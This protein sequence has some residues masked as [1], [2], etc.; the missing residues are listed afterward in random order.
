MLPTPAR[1][2]VSLA[3]ITIMHAELLTHRKTTQHG[4]TRSNAACHCAASDVPFVGTGAG[5][6]QALAVGASAGEI[7]AGA[8]SGFSHGP[9]AASSVLR[10]CEHVIATACSEEPCFKLEDALGASVWA[11]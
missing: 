11:A 8:L 10:H 2:Y 1:A 9:S 7:S 6:G 4:T 5:A 3:W